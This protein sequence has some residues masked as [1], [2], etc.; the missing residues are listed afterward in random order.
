MYKFLLMSPN[1]YHSTI[2]P[3]SYMTTCGTI[4]PD[5]AINYQVLIFY[6]PRFNSFNR[7]V[8][9]HTIVKINKQEFLDFDGTYNVL[10]Q[11]RDTAYKKHF[12]YRN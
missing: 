5:Q 8:D 6:F 11:E 2:T 9:I 1:K 7:T 3:Y 12:Y 10:R 4:H